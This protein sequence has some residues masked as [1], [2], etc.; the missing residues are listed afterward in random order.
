MCPCIVCVDGIFSRSRRHIRWGLPSDHF[1]YVDHARPA[2]RWTDTLALLP[3]LPRQARAA[4]PVNRSAY[5]S[6][7]LEI[8]RQARAVHL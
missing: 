3:L 4:I 1:F 2:P 6:V 7:R 5:P 8:Y